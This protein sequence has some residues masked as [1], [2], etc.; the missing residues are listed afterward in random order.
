MN[1]GPSTDIF[2]VESPNLHLKNPANVFNIF[3]SLRVPRPSELRYNYVF[4]RGNE[5]RPSLDIFFFTPC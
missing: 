3:R 1:I 2:Q 4:G 5:Y